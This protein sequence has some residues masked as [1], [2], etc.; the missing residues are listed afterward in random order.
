M[1]L[2][3]LLPINAALFAKLKIVVGSIVAAEGEVSLQME[4]TAK[5]SDHRAQEIAYCPNKAEDL[6]ETSNDEEQMI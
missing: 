3:I 5:T 1:N 2:K 6:K 4:G